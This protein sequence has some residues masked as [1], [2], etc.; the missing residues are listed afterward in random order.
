M[1]SFLEDSRPVVKCQSKHRFW[2]RQGAIEVDPN[3][4][5]TELN[6]IPKSKGVNEDANL[7]AITQEAA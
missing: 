7:G 5:T 3:S 6:R 2:R 1:D 4:R